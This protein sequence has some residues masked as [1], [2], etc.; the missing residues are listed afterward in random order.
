MKQ[1][2][3]LLAMGVTFT[4]AS[5]QSRTINVGDATINI[6]IAGEGAPLVLIHG[7]A[8]DLT[9]W[10]EQ[11]PVFAKNYRVIRYDRRG[12]GQ[13]TGHSD[14]SSDPDD[15]RVLLDSL[16]IR[17]AYL[18]GLSAGSRAALNFAVAFPERVSALVIYGQALV[19]G[20]TPVPQGPTPLMV[21]R[22]IAQKH[23]LDSAG[24]ALMA[25]PL[26][27]SPPDRPD[28]RARFETL[29]RNYSGRDLL[30]PQPESN[31]V[32]HANLDQIATLRIPTLVVS[33]D[34]DLPLFLAVGDTLV[35]RI[36]GAQRLIIT[37]AGHG[38]HFARPMQFND[39]ILRFL[40]KVP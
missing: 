18:L 8:Q 40:Q 15:L 24:R 30:D 13:S 33:G 17:A 25:H 6:E 1:L 26:T 4:P 36:P 32:A 38:A 7:W 27:W 10:D 22:D 19:P 35:R 9:I 37:N 20:F 14:P 34:H 11:V 23:G 3:F 39:T 16:N 21:F 5:A 29:W 31:R 28:V 12:Y 2:L